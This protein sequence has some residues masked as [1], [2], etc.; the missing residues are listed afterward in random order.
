[1]RGRETYEKSEEE[2]E[3]DSGGDS[4]DDGESWGNEEKGALNMFGE[5]R[6]SN[7]EMEGTKTNNI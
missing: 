7:N 5:M 3:E 1:M 2:K 6:Y 4:S